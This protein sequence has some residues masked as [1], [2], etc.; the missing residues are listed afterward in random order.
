MGNGKKYSVLLASSSA[1]GTAALS[2]IIESGVCADITAVK[3]AEKARQALMTSKYDIVV[4]DCPLSDE[5]GFDFSVSVSEK[6]LSQVMV[7]ARYDIFSGVSLRLSPKGIIT[8][9][10]PLDKDSIISGLYFL[11]GISDKIKRIEQ[12]NRELRNKLN[13][14]RLVARAKNIL[15]TNLH[16]SEP[17]A[18]RYIEK[19]AM[20]MRISKT[21]VA[22]LIIAAYNDSD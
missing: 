13:E 4:V 5:A 1:K 18:H 11:A 8:E 9:K 22:N 3:T 15:I 6:N 10:K 14:M 12:D 21:N 17:Q 2:N 16:M 7:I 20:D 19:Q